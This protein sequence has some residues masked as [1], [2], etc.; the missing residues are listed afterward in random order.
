MPKN[1]QNLRNS[2]KLTVL[3]RLA[4]LIRDVNYE[5]NDVLVGFST[6]G[7]GM[8]FSHRVTFSEYHRKKKIPRREKSQITVSKAGRGNPDDVDWSRHPGYEWD[9]RGSVKTQLPF[10][11]AETFKG[12]IE[13]GLTIEWL[14][15]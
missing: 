2:D 5:Q 13:D 1:L 12:Q 9:R 15:T 6:D 3:W 4:S 11:R 14:L 10:W 8:L 7:T